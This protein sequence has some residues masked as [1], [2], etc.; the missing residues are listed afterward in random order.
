MLESFKE[1]F[2]NLVDLTMTTLKMT[3]KEDFDDEAMEKDIRTEMVK[4]AMFIIS[5]AGKVS[6]EDTQTLA[7]IY[8]VDLAPADIN[9]MV[10]ELPDYS[11]II[12]KEPSLL[13]KN[14]VVIDNVIFKLP[15][16]FRTELSLCDVYY[17]LNLNIIK[18]LI[19]DD[20]KND[21]EI[22]GKIDK[23]FGYIKDYTGKN[24]L[25]KDE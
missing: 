22:S 11:E 12:D 6:W 3:T 18:S 23:Y 8:G 21:E 16:Q 7:Y 13:L 17:T 1:A 24:V 15:D 4:R 5:S 2:D 20:R 25:K 14:L 19:D 10:R 9:I